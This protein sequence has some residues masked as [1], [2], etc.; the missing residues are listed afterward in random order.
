[1]CIHNYRSIRDLSI[2][3]QSLMVLLGPNNHGKSNILSA[4]GFALTPSERPSVRDFCQFRGEDDT[5]WV[6]LVFSD[7]T[8][9]EKKTFHKYLLD[10]DTVRV[11]KTALLKDDSAVETFYNGY[12]SEPEDWW[13]RSESLDKLTKREEIEKT[14]LKDLIPSSGRVTK[15]I[16][17]EAQ[18][19]FIRMNKGSLTFS[20]AMDQGPFLG[21]KPVGGGVLPDFYLV[22]AVKYLSDE[23]KIKTTTVFGRLLNRAVREMAERDPRFVTLREGMANLVR[24][25]NRQ[26]EGQAGRPE[27]LERLEARIAAELDSWGVHVDIEVLPPDLAKVFE[28]GTNLYIDDGVRT[29]AEEK[30]HGLQRAV[31]F[32]LVRAWAD[33][34]RPVAAQQGEIVARTSSDSLIFAIEE[35]ELFLH[36]HAQRQFASAIRKLADNEHHQVFICS[37]STHF[38]DL[39]QYR[40]I[41]IVTKNKIEEGT[42]AKQCTIDLFEEETDAD[43]K[44]RF[45][46]AH[47]V[48]PD[49]SELFFARKVIFVEGETEKAVFPFLA[50]KLGIK[51]YDVSIVDCGSKHNLPLYIKVANAFS[52]PYVVVHDEDPLPDPI[53]KHWDEDE[54]KARGRTYALNAEINALID[55]KIGSVA[56]LKGDFESFAGIS[57]KQGKKKG[58]SIAALEHFSSIKPEDIPQ[59]LRELV[60]SIFA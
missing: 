22:P 38:V 45:H 52:I 5:L 10:G 41:A 60:A 39:A 3:C 36:P 9:Q 59:C 18:E 23:T 40:S 29:L 54:K 37:H 58:K 47:W 20:I 42:K 31:L 21:A 13:L 14:K 33:A 7:L 43:K 12:T 53:P 50:D 6:E 57:R 28:L 27:Q 35:P 51:H 8:E 24:T 55:R 4:L 34:L 2:D 46:M 25:L 11:R 48:N 15:R 44:S 19:T 32:A 49:R 1:M 16:A 56:P 30:G 26:E 17:Q